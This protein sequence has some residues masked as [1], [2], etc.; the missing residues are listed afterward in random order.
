MRDN[1]PTDSG[2]AAPTL[3]RRHAAGTESARS[4]LFTV[5]GELVLPTG[6]EAWTSAFIGV[7]GRRGGEE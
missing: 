7:V 3:L 1:K 6:G 5:L 2:G 4:L